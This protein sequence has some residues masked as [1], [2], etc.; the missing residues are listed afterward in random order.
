MGRDVAIG[1]HLITDSDCL[2]GGRRAGDQFQQAAPV[3]SRR[4]LGRAARCRLLL[5]LVALVLLLQICG[6]FRV[7]LLR[8]LRL[9]AKKALLG[10]KRSL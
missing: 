8:H 6:E 9:A 1:D 10:S 4:R 2:A 7:V 3:D 5:A